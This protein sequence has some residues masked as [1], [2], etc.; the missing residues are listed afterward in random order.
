MRY[1]LITISDTDPIRASRQLEDEVNKVLIK[2][3]YNVAGGVT[4]T[5]LGD[6]I[7]FSQVIIKHSNIF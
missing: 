3:D 6:V 1:K 7:V 5:T 4:V 2:G